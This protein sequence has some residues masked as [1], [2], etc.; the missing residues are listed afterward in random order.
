METASIRELFVGDCQLRRQP[1]FI[2]DIF[3][4]QMIIVQIASHNKRIQFMARVSASWTYSKISR[5]VI[6]IALQTSIRLYA[7][8]HSNRRRLPYCAW[9][10]S[11]QFLGDRERERESSHCLWQTFSVTT[12]RRWQHTGDDNYWLP[13]SIGLLPINDLQSGN[14]YILPHCYSWMADSL[15]APTRFW[16]AAYAYVLS[17]G[18]TVRTATVRSFSLAPSV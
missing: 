12:N 17:I 5:I 4:L 2:N 7:W 14:T 10:R 18:H 8:V 3:I 1:I 9:R 15:I 6:R 16:P 13:T 11:K